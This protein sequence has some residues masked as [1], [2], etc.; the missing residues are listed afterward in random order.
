MSCIHMQVLVAA[1]CLPSYDPLHGV[2]FL[3]ICVKTLQ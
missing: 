2:S 3:Q 1:L